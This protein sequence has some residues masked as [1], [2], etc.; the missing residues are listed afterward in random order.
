[1][2]A[3]VGRSTMAGGPGKATREDGLETLRQAALW[4]SVG[5]MFM[6]EGAPGAKTLESGVCRGPPRKVKE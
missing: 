5:G 1:M 4:V 3:E 2:G 6:A